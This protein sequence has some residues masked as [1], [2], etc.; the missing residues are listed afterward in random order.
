MRKLK[1]MK[2]IS[3]SISLLFVCIVAIFGITSNKLEA[4]DI[5]NGSNDL[6]NFFGEPFLKDNSV[7]FPP[8]INGNNINIIS[9]DFGATTIWSKDKLDMDYSWDLNSKIDV[10][11]LKDYDLGDGLTF[12]LAKDGNDIGQHGAGLG[13]AGIDNGIA[14][15][16]NYWKNSGYGLGVST[17]V[18][19]TKDFEIIDKSEENMVPSTNNK[20]DFNVS[21]N[22]ESKILSYK[23]GEYSKSIDL[24]SI[25][26]TITDS[27]NKLR[28]GYSAAT[29]EAAMIADFTFDDFMYTSVDIDAKQELYTD[30]N[31]TQ[32]VTETNPLRYG[33]KGYIKVSIKNNSEI[34]SPKLSLRPLLIEGSTIGN[35][36]IP[37]N[38]G[39]LMVDGVFSDKSMIPDGDLTND[40]SIQPKGNSLTNIT[41][42]FDVPKSENMLITS[43]LIAEGTTTPYDL[44]SSGPIYINE[45]V[46]SFDAN[47]GDGSMEPQTM[48]VDVEE[49]VDIN[50]FTKIGYKFLNWNTKADGTG[51]SVADGETMIRDTNENI[52]LYAEWESTNNAPVI[53]LK[54]KAI[55]LE[56]GVK[57]DMA[58]YFT[59]TDDEDDTVELAYSFDQ[60]KGRALVEFEFD[61]NKL[62][63]HILLMPVGNYFVDLT[64]TDTEGL[65][66]T[67]RIDIK[68]VE[69][70]VTPPPVDPGTSVTPEGTIVK[71]QISIDK[72]ENTGVTSTLLT[73]AALVA[74]VGLTLI[75]K[76]VLNK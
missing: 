44:A 17:G 41:Y 21:W 36:I 16:V 68:I 10:K 50:K 59:V 20:H 72:L 66:T 76:K 4:L 43:S 5:P 62:N 7:D 58:S 6:K 13:V 1:K 2:V 45:Y 33:D 9:S 18:V 42:S 26:P 37:E 54:S 8:V 69:S 40:L 73:S 74:A 31:H 52:S 49:K 32:L 15:Y 23:I 63:N 35:I 46:I 11:T 60:V 14:L 29:G 57:P 3:I 51:D 12:V 30:P 24:T 28:V 64:A 55:T 47:G 53:A 22:A 38:I 48:R 39:E 71:P 34:Q 27:E 65:S 19:K 67:K 25:L 75:G 56:K 70:Q 61:V